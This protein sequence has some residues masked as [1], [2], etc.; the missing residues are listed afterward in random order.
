MGAP[1]V[2]G[3]IVVSALA[4]NELIG[5]AIGSPQ[6][7]VVEVSTLLSGAQGA[8]TSQTPPTTRQIIGSLLADYQGVV[9]VGGGSGSL[10]GVRGEMQVAAGTTLGPGYYY[11]AQG[12]IDGKGT[13]GAGAWAVGILGQF[14]LSQATVSGNPSLAAVWAD[15][16]ATAPT[17]GWGSNSAI[18]RGYN[19]TADAVEEQLHL[20]GKATYFANIDDNNHGSGFVAAA[21][22]SSGSAGYASGCNANYVLSCYINGAAAFIPVFS[23]NA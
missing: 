11:G 16:G 1:S 7:A 2:P 20:Y 4:G 19:T 21:G 5:V 6:S 10:V 15:M 23:S 14:D 22:T 12:K 18:I 9:T 17:S 3:A 13:I 8:V